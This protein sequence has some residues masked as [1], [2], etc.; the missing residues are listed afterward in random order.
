MAIIK[1]NEGKFLVKYARNIIEN[2]FRGADA[3]V[4]EKKKELLSMSK[5]IYVVFRGF[6]KGYLRGSAGYP[7]AVLPLGEAIRELT[8]KAATMDRRY[9]PIKSD[10]LGSVI[11]EVSIL[12][13]PEKLD[14]SS[15]DYLNKIRIGRDGLI[16]E[17]GGL[18]S[19]MLPQFPLEQQWSV[20]ELLSLTCL[21]AGI[22]PDVCSSA[23]TNL[24]RFYAAIFSEVEPRGKIIKKKLV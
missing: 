16:V 7:E 9:H 15:K 11:I 20:K 13:K 12:S 8:I 5:G 2:Y 10:E 17:Y 6:P 14:M 3:K 21:K 23:E 18:K 24:Y 19:V 22:E 4:S 1:A